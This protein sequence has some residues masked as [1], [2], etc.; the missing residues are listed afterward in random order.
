[1][2]VT[3]VPLM[4]NLVRIVALFS[5]LIMILALYEPYAPRDSYTVAKNGVYIQNSAQAALLLDAT[6]GRILFSQ[7]ASARLPMAST[8]KIMTAI[9]A[10]ENMPTDY[11][12]TVAK[13]AVGI[14]GS[15]IYLYAGEQITC[16]DLLYGLMLESGNDAAV[17]LAIAVGGTEERF[18]MLMNEKAK[19]LG[20]KDTRFSNP[21]GLPAEN[22]FTSVA[23]L[24]RLT[25]YALQNEL[26][27]EIVSTKK[28]TACEG[29]RYYVNHNRLLFSYEGMIGVKTGYTQASGRCLVTAARRYGRTLICV[30]L[31]DYYCSADHVR[32]LDSGF[33]STD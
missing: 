30:T 29:T 1:M 27:A 17:A 5:A 21:H 26:F 25:D 31:N 20:L 13:E 23:D 11:V 15:S 19:E 33:S 8:T 24:A 32:M 28:M 9:V 16:L 6:E 12:V 3:S 4:K 18:I 22:H 7:N 10:I 2:N 14:E